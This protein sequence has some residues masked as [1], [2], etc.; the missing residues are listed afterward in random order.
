LNAEPQITQRPPQPYAGIPLTVT[1]TTFASAI[2]AGFPELF[3][4]LGE[5]GIEM[6]G[7]PFIRYNVIDMAGDL[8]VELAVPVAGDAAQAAASGR[9]GRVRAG[10]LPGGGYVTLLHTGP[11]DGLVGANAAL[12]QWA[13]DHG[14]VLESS[15]DQRRWQGRVEHYLTD[16]TAEPD[17]ARWQTEVAYLISDDQAA[18]GS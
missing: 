11:Y 2:D 6:T 16:P 14:M 8:E 12:Q 13:A 4:W 18:G 3:G 15:P 1:M 5:H 10:V 7:P 9:E 17:P